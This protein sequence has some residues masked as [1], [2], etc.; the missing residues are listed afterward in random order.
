MS[1]Y[2]QKKNSSQ[3]VKIIIQ[4]PHDV[5]WVKQYKPQALVTWQQNIGQKKCP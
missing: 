3:K 2:Q 4:V 5:R 1:D